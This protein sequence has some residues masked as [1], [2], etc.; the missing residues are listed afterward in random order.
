MI[1]SLHEDDKS[2]QTRI[3]TATNALTQ[4]VGFHA[5]CRLVGIRFA[6]CLSCP[7]LAEQVK[8]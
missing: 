7:K 8:A 4:V 2:S 3:A 5:H 1:I 6:L